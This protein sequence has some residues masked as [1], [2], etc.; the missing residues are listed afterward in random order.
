[1]IVCHRPLTSL[2]MSPY[3]P[4]WTH[5]RQIFMIF[6]D[7]IQTNFHDFHRFNSSNWKS[8]WHLGLFFGPLGQFLIFLE[9]KKYAQRPYDNF[10]GW[11]KPYR[12]IWIHFRQILMPTSIPRFPDAAGAGAGRI[13]R[14]QPGPSPNASRDQIRRKGPCCDNCLHDVGCSGSPHGFLQS[15]R[16]RQTR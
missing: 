3:R 16:G 15:Q 1:M 11:I 5:F 8:C 13:L 4:I 6:I 9:N 10:G 7:L 12:A 14:S 2:N